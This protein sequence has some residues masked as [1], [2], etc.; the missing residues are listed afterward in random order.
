MQKNPLRKVSHA[1]LIQKR[2][3]FLR[4]G[5]GD[6]V[7]LEGVVESQIET[8]TSTRAALVGFRCGAICGAIAAVLVPTRSD[9]QVRRLIVKLAQEAEEGVLVKVEADRGDFHARSEAGKQT[10][11]KSKAVFIEAY[12]AGKDAFQK[13]KSLRSTPPP[14]AIHS[15]DTPDA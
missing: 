11:A 15:G 12:E 5:R 1:L 7:L 6:Y 10:F 8:S 3:Y 2:E 14:M 13:E 9:E 4:A